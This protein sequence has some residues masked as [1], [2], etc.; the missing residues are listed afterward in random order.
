MTEGCRCGCLRVAEVLLSA[1][2]VIAPVVPGIGRF[3]LSSARVGANRWIIG[4][5]RRSA[6]D[7]PGAVRHGLV[8]GRD[9]RQGGHSK[10]TI[11]RFL[12]AS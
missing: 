10:K 6:G 11:A 7:L 8:C 12:R 4:T 9:P 1:A 3:L 5:C 2:R